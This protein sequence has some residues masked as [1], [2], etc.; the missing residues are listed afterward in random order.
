M[1]IL[2]LVMLALAMLCLPLLVFAQADRWTAPA[3]FI[4]PLDD[5][6]VS[7]TAIVLCPANANQM[8]CTCRNTGA[9][10]MRIGDST[11]TSTKGLPLAA[12]ESME[13]RTRSAVYGI[14]EGVDTTAA[15]LTEVQ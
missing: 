4:P 14:S 12:N 15:C 2:V 11:V 1:K 9:V 8:N 5:V 13:I 10:T 6:T 7:N 3:N